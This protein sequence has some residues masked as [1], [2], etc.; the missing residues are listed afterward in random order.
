MKNRA[1]NL[2]KNQT[3]A[4]KLLWSSLRN[5][6]IAG[7]KFRRQWPIGPYIV[8]FAC[9]SRKL[10]IELDGGQHSEAIAYDETRTKFLEAQGYRVIRFWN[11][12]MLT[13]PTAVLQRIYEELMQ[14]ADRPSPQPSPHGGEGEKP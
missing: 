11:N 1:R 14:G 9:L 7:C 3:E 4:E 12:E 13:E 2:R 6:Q 8:D 5:R 10:L